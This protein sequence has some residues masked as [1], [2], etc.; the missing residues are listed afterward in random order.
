MSGG[1]L[2]AT[3]EALNA[4]F[5]NVIMTVSSA[6][7]EKARDSVDFLRSMGGVEK[8]LLTPEEVVEFGI[9]KDEKAAVDPRTL[10]APQDGYHGEEFNYWLVQPV[11]LSEPSGGID[12]RMQVDR[13]NLQQP[14]EGHSPILQI[15]DYLSGRAEGHNVFLYERG[16]HSAITSADGHV[17]PVTI[18][19]ICE[20]A[21]KALQTKL[22]AL[23]MHMP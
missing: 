23:G 6:V 3:Y 7:V 13:A 21:T 2:K 1:L 4:N 20:E 14:A 11:R 17:S 18:S 10:D 15:G 9:T 22:P 16:V 8:Y 12:Y 19:T 5:G